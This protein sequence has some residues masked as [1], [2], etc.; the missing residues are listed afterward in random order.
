MLP[1]NCTNGGRRVMIEEKFFECADKW[2]KYDEF[3][4]LVLE[5]NGED[6]EEYEKDN[7]NN[8]WPDGEQRTSFLY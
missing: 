2:V 8:N 4:Q 6:P 3:M 7:E 5:A 1:L